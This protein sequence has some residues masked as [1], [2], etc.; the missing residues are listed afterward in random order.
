MSILHFILFVLIVAN[1][2]QAA[3]TSSSINEL[4]C[5][6]D[7]NFCK[8]NSKQGGLIKETFKSFDLS[9]LPYKQLHKDVVS[10]KLKTILLTGSGQT[11]LIGSN[12]LQQLERIEEIYLESFKVEMTKNALRSNSLKS[13]VI[14][15]CVARLS[16]P[17]DAFD[18]VPQLS[19][20]VI[21]NCSLKSF[22]WRI[23]SKLKKWTTLHLSM[24]E[25]KTLG[26]DWPVFAGLK[27]SL[28]QI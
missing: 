5:R 4:V 8:F 11:F 7:K 1:V 27:L 21:V 24:N 23:V 13:F 12:S 18:G 28:I 2:F 26:A 22:S 17:E 9:N 3:E 6:F 10:S 19:Y 15:H 20:L 14:K 25:I 16:L